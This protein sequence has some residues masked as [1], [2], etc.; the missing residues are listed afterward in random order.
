MRSFAAG[1]RATG[2][3]RAVFVAL[4]IISSGVACAPVD[5]APAR[6]KTQ[7]LA[8]VLLPKA[9]LPGPGELTRAFGRFATSKDQRLQ[10]KGTSRDEK[11]KSEVLEL[12][13][14][15][16]GAAFVALM[17]VAVPKREADEAARFSV[18]ALGTGWKLPAHSAHLVVTLQDTALGSPTEALSRFTS[19]L[20]AVTEASGAVGVYWGNA[21]ATHD[22]KFFISTAQDRDV[23][24]RIALWTGVSLA[25][26]KDGRLSLLSLGMKQLN[27]PDLLLIAP[28][29]DG[30]AALGTFFDLLAYVVS[31][32]KALP[33]GDTVGRTAEERLPVRYAPSP[34]DSKVKVW[35]VELE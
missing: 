14:S 10:V 4:S 26:E 3:R 31:K 22:P 16:G 5:A 8:F 13:V 24:A 34:L 9:H 12:E 18:S 1:R 32:G 19:L 30:S 25:R 35:R 29:A 11:T 27:L 17:P 33:E 7:N 6:G 2:I 21:G 15:P 23:A 20:A 28:K